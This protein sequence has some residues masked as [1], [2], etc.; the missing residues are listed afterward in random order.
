MAPSFDSAVSSLLCT[1]DNNSIFGDVS[2]DYHGVVVE[3]FEPT[4]HH[5]N[6]QT[7]IDD[8]GEILPSQSDECL[9]LML[10]KECQHLPNS[11]Y[12]KRLQTGDLDLVAR[13]EAVDWIF[14]VGS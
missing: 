6:H 13:K 12:W 5:G 11:D 14:K 9:A 10:E 4:W 2:T 8:Y 3:E 7:H 1:E